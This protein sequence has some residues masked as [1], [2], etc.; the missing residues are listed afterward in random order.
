M[1][2]VKGCVERGLLRRIAPSK[3]KALQCI[4]K[5]SELL[6]EARACLENGQLNA[7]VLAGYTALLNA[8]RAVLFRDGWR[9]R[10]HECTIRY[11]EKNYGREITPDVITLLERYKTSRHDTQYDVTYSPDEMEAA[12][13]LEFT[14]E[15]IKTARGIIENVP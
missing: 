15:F 10:S 6:E 11:L 5:S 2:D 12:S 8:E 1:I 7:T 9:E 13:L 3:E 14:E 4:K